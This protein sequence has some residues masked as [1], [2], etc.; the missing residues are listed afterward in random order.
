MVF[1]SVRDCLQ[2]CIS[3]YRGSLYCFFFKSYFLAVRHHM[4]S[5][6]FYYLVISSR[7]SF[8]VSSSR[9]V[10]I[11]SSSRVLSSYRL[12]VS[13]RRLIL[14][15]HR[16]IVSFVLPSHRLDRI[17]VSC[18]LIISLSL[19]Y[20]RLVLIVSSSLSC[21]RFCCVIVFPFSV[22]SSSSSIISSSL[23]GIVSRLIVSSFV[24]SSYIVSSSSRGIV[25]RLIAFH[26]LF[27]FLV[28]ECKKKGE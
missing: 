5:P 19:S 18:F 25:S 17:I 15:S 27:L 12:L 4:F 28:L 6:C 16:T 10:L 26:F 23:R 22:V 9:I 21:P 3:T 2:F 11:V 14:P 24:T 1:L 13:Y 7:R 8:I 20:H